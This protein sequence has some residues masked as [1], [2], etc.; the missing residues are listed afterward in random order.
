MR[1]WIVLFVALAVAANLT[2][3]DS[4]QRK[5]TRKKKTVKKPRIYQLNKYDIKPSPEL[6]EK[7]FA[8]W[9]SWSSEIIQRLGD[10]H[11]KD[12][13][14]IEEIIGQV[15]DMQNLLVDAKANELEKRAKAYERIRDT[16]VRDQLTDDNRNS[17]LMDLEREDRN[18]GRDFC[19]SKVKNYI[20]KEWDEGAAG[21]G[22][23]TAPG[24]GAAGAEAVEREK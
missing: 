18:I 2:A 17:V 6:Y 16:I 24:A 15:N 11:K 5:F 3:C 23:G 13:R 22:A 9:R 19:V 10:N 8:Y 7:H 1:K 12:A 14:C 20:K 21:E 4:L